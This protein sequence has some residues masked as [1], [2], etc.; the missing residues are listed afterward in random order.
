AALPLLTAGLRGEQA[1]QIALSHIEQARAAASQAQMLVER[2]DTARRELQAAL[3]VR[4][5]FLLTA[6][7]ELR[8]PLTVL[9]GHTQLLQRRAAAEGSHS[10]RDQRALAVIAARARKLQHLIGDLLDVTRIQ[11]GRLAIDCQSFDLRA[12]VEQLVAEM[13]PTLEQHTVS[14]LALETPLLVNADAFRIEQV[15][16]NLLDNAVKYSPAGGPIRVHLAAS[17]DAVTISVADPGLGI[18]AEAQA[19]VFEQFFRAGNASHSH[20]AGLGIGLYLVHE[21]VTAHGGSVAV[22]STEGQGSTFTVTLPRTM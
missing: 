4:D 13:Q 21:I 8:T 20:I 7:H 6:A 5:Q 11:T 2:L 1:A 15:L 18:P 14:L 17:G 3:R 10:G 16:Q 19:Q 22:V 12:L 9:L